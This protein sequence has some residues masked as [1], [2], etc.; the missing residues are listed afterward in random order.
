MIIYKKPLKSKLI[1]AAF[2]GFVFLIFP[3]R[4][5]CVDFLQEIEDDRDDDQDC[6][7]ADSDGSDAGDRLHD[8]RQDGDDAQE[9]R[10]DERDAAD[11]IADIFLGRIART[12]ARNECA[13]LLKIGRERMRIKSHRGIEVCEKE[14]EY[15]IT[16]AVEPLRLRESGEGRADMMQDRIARIRE[17]RADEL[18]KE[19]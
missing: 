14:Y 5:L 16:D 17:E 10:A 8:E 2:L 15:E 13:V 9:E 11:D 1:L 19:Q 7:A 18:R 3:H 6:G 4:E 12:D